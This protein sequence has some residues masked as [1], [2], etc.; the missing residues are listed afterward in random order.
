M[1]PCLMGRFYTTTT[2]CRA[3]WQRD[4]ALAQTTI[5]TTEFGASHVLVGETGVVVRDPEAFL[6]ES[7]LLHAQWHERLQSL[8]AQRAELGR[9]PRPFGTASA[10]TSARCQPARTA[11]GAIPPTP[12][13]CRH[14]RGLPWQSG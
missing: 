3:I 1:T 10:E 2:I 13:P 5:D 6:N 9:R 8:G 14:S 7:V 4:A 11:M 12:A